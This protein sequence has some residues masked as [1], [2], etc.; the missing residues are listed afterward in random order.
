MVDGWDEK[1]RT[2]FQSIPD[3]KLIDWKLL[4]RDPVASWVSK[5]GR[6]A[7]LGDAAHPHLPSSGQGAA[8]AIEDGATVGAVLDR[9]GKDVAL[10]FRVYEKLRWTFTPTL[11]LVP[12]LTIYILGLLE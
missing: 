5:N 6:I 2:I 11:S 8:Q 9:A 4:W 12:D 3:E 10:G 7:L 1:L